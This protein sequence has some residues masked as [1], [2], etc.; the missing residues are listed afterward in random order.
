MKKTRIAFLATGLFT[1]AGC[2]S[3]SQTGAPLPTPLPTIESFSAHRGTLW[4]AGQSG[5]TLVQETANGFV[6]YGVASD[7]EVVF[8]MS[9]GADELS[10][11]KHIVEQQTNASAKPC[12]PDGPVPCPPGPTGQE[13]Q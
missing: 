9:G 11:L 12:L 6:A 4:P 8:R 3:G 2:G 13:H 10:T 7:G 1:L 5:T